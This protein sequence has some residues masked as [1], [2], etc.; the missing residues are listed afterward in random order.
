VLPHQSAVL[1]MWV[2]SHN[3][4]AVVLHDTPWIKLQSL[5]HASRDQIASVLVWKNA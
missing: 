3:S 4:R 2:D 1:A 5:K